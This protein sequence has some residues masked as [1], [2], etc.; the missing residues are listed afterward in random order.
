MKRL[1]LM[2]VLALGIAQCGFAQGFKQHHSPT[3]TAD[4][5]IFDVTMPNAK[6]VSLAGEWMEGMD[7]YKG[8]PMQKGS[9]GKWYYRIAKPKGE[10]YMYSINVDGTQMPDPAN[11][12]V[13]RDGQS[14]RSLLYIRS[15][16]EPFVSYD[17]RASKNKGQIVKRWYMSTPHGYQRRL[18]VYLPYGYDQGTKRYPV[19]YLQHGGGGDED[20]WA[21]IGRCAQIMDYLIEKGKAE[22]MIIVMPNGMPVNEASADVMMPNVWV[23]DMQSR[24]FMEGTNYVK[25]IYTD[26][27]PF[28]DS[29]Y[30]TIADK[31]HRAI[32]GLSMG[33]IYTE[34]VTRQHPELF[35]Y[36]GEL[37]MGL[38]PDMP[39]EEFLGPVKKAGYKLYYVGC[40]KTDIAWQN[41]ER[42]MEGLK[43]LDMPY[44]YFDKDLGGHCWATW[45]KCLFDFSQR[46]FK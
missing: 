34:Q 21:S 40:G 33:G 5:V 32:A 11:F 39:A 26:I 30:R 23:E 41:A 15:N 37:S 45:R 42:T 3:V 10:I 4:S 16:E 36:I 24:D 44:V 25:S 46:L 7:A 27:I 31:A 13:Y 14:P 9:D 38:T 17:D 12:L 43:K 20:A 18:T 35:D 1:K 29:H 6:S 22:P 19:L 2:L 8:K 28:I